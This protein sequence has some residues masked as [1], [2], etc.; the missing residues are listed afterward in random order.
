[1]RANVLGNQER[2]ALETEVA[3]RAWHG[4]ESA[5]T[6]NLLRQ[7]EPGAGVILP[8]ALSLR[9]LP[10]TLLLYA[11]CTVCSGHTQI[12]RCQNSSHVCL[13]SP[14]RVFRRFILPQTFD[15]LLGKSGV[16]VGTSEALTLLL[17]Q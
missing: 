14:R 17:I 12:S 7:K 1:V 2:P 8:A 13:N 16:S 6:D 15:L 9:V 3:T 10:E 5:Q 4:S 11:K